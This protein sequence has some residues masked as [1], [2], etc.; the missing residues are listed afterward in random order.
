[1]TRGSA[2][3]ASKTA[4]NPHKTPNV[5]DRF[6][7]TVTDYRN[8][9]GINHSSQ[10]PQ[11]PDLYELNYSEEDALSDTTPALANFLKVYFDFVYF[12]LVC[13]F[14]IG[15]DERGK[16]IIKKCRPQMVSYFLFKKYVIFFMNFYRYI[17]F[18]LKI[19]FYV[20]ECNSC[21][22]SDYFPK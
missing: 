3:S 13:P 18:F 19:R 21:V 10:T 15:V 14:R 11:S 9:Y 5:N 17:F 12:L 2:K 6:I 20:L 4:I 1:M 22:S 8:N 7:S 16:F